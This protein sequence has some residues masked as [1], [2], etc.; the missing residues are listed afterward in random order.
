[1]VVALNVFKRHEKNKLTHDAHGT[2]I[3]AKVGKGMDCVWSGNG[4][5]GRRHDHAA[6]R[7]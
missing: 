5:N 6:R 3:K 4:A 2:G 1:M 7:I